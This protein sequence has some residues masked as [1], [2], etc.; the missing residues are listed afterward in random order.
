M[1]NDSVHVVFRGELTGEVPEEQVKDNLTQLFRQP[2][3]RID[4]LFGGKAVTVKKGV[5]EATARRFEAAFRKAG[6]VCELQPAAG[7]A[8]SAGDRER[9]GGTPGRAVDPA[10]GATGAAG[11]PNRTIVPL[12]VP[13]DLGGLALD[14]SGAPLAPPT[15]RA[16]PDIDTSGLEL[17]DAAGDG[18]PRTQRAAPDIDTGGLELAPRPGDEP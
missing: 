10:A 1:A 8:D 12:A 2:R 17:G 16:P 14:D 13:D 18:A 4:A 3:E 11:D 9:A 5:D 15:E 7:A 6:A